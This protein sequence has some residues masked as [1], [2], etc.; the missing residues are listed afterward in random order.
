MADGPMSTPRR[1]APRSSGAP[2]SAISLAAGCTPTTARLT[3]SR[4][5]A[6]WDGRG[7]G[8]RPPRGRRPRVSRLAPSADRAPAGPDGGGNGRERPRRH[9]LAAEL[10]PDAVVIDLHMPS[11]D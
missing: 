2:M 3:S 7:A 10:D 11:V 4:G 6:G 5:A 1:P 9:R 8:G